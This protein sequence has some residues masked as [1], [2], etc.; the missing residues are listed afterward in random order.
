MRRDNVL[1]ALDA[2]VV[3]RVERVCW[4]SARVV[5]HVEFECWE[6]ARVSCRV[7]HSFAFS[8]VQAVRRECSCVLSL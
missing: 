5:G 7:R 6:G 2:H 8:G 4:E 1:P 3:G